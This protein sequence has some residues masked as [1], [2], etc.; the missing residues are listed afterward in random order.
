MAFYLSKASSWVN[1]SLSVG[2][3][4]LIFLMQLRQDGISF[5]A[6]SQNI[7]I[8]KNNYNQISQK[9]KSVIEEL[10]V[11]PISHFG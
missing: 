2:I 3:K 4:R 1:V 6:A 7:L 11:S 8:C 5:L 10:F 9:K